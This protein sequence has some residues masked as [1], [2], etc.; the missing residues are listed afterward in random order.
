MWRR[1]S[2]SGWQGTIKGGF[3]GAVILVGCGVCGRVSGKSLVG[4]FVRAFF[5]GFC[6]GGGVQLVPGGSG[7]RAPLGGAVAQNLQGLR[8]APARF[9]LVCLGPGG[10]GPVFVHVASFI[11]GVGLSRWSQRGR[12]FFVYDSCWIFRLAFAA[13]QLCAGGTFAGVIG[14]GFRAW[15]GC[16]RCARAGPDGPGLLSGCGGFS[17]DRSAVRSGPGH[18]LSIPDPNGCRIRI[19]LWVCGLPGPGLPDRPGAFPLFFKMFCRIRV[20]FLVL[21]SAG[22]RSRRAACD[23]RPACLT[24]SRIMGRV[25]CRSHSGSMVVRPA[26]RTVA[27]TTIVVAKNCP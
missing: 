8:V 13:L 7:I 5:V 3:Y 20:R 11:K 14:P 15:C 22:R 27:G 26:A 23:L 12:P 1:W 16:G 2:P 10:V 17:C 18:S 4:A 25:G 21:R 19:R 6:A 24:A 9:V